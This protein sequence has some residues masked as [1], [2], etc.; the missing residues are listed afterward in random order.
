MGEQTC[1]N[2]SCLWGLVSRISDLVRVS[3]P[4]QR[5]R[6]LHLAFCGC[7]FWPFRPFMAF[8]STL[9]GLSSAITQ[10]LAFSR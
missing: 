5:L 6:G 7:W 2:T 3:G 8:Y 4:Y 10:P 1:Q 9:L